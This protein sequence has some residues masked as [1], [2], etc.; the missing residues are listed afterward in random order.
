[1]QSL[2]NMCYNVRLRGQGTRLLKTSSKYWSKCFRFFCLLGLKPVVA[3]T[4][5]MTCVF[6]GCKIAVGMDFSRTVHLMPL[7][8]SRIMWR[9]NTKVV[10]ANEEERPLH[11]SRESASETCPQVRLTQPGLPEKET[12]RP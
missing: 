6:E 8:S 11:I 7:G 1:M 9:F 2:G 10:V 4:K 5:H 3:E 12:P